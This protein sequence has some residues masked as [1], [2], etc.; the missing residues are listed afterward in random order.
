MRGEIFSGTNSDLAH[1]TVTARRFDPY[2]DRL[3][4]L[5]ARGDERPPPESCASNS[6]LALGAGQRRKRVISAGNPPGSGLHERFEPRR[7]DRLAPHLS[8][9]GGA[10]GA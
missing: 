4:A 6:A 5:S 7:V 2:K 3:W 8:W 1:A 9:C 10:G